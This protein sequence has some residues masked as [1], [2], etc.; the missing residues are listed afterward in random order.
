MEENIMRRDNLEW[1][2][3]RLS[4]LTNGSPKAYRVNL[5]HCPEGGYQ[6]SRADVASFMLQ[7]TH[8]DTYLRQTP[9]LCY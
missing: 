7:Q 6:I 1:V 8:E 5:R 4:Q 2:I 3:V 9:A